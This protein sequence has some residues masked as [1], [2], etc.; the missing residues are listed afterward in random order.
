MISIFRNSIGAFLALGCLLQS[1]EATTEELKALK[2]KVEEV[3]STLSEIAHKLQEF[4]TQKVTEISSNPSFSALE[5]SEPINPPKP[6]VSLIESSTRNVSRGG[7]VRRFDPSGFYILPFLGLLTSGNLTWDSLF[8]GE[9]DIEEGVGTSTGISI[10][11]EGKNFFSDLQLSYMQNRMKSMDLPF[12]ASF[13]GMTKGMGVHLTGGGRIH[14]NEYISLSLGAGIGGVEQD[15]SFLLS[16]ISVQEKDFLMSYQIFTGIEYRPVE[17]S[18]MGLRYRWLSIDEMD[19]FSSRDL[20][21]IELC[22]GYL[23]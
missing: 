4:K 3:R 8:L 5:K 20:H 12:S 23:F 2:I 11:Y 14:F 15:M 21:L 7:E 6:K 18:S 19:M 13:S 9:F 16:G 22:L 17:S 1:V 10:G